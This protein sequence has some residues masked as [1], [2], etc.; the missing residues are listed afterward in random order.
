[1]EVSLNATSRLLIAV[2]FSLSAPSLLT[3]CVKKGVHEGVLDQLAQRNAAY[4]DLAT[5][6]VNCETLAADRASTISSTVLELEQ[7]TGRLAECNS[8][9]AESR[10]L[11]EQSGE[12]T[13]LL[14]SRLAD[15]AAV[16]A[17]LRERDAIFRSII[18]RFQSL[19][20]NGLLEVVV[21]R[22]RLSLKLPQDILFEPGSAEVGEEGEVT[23]REVATVL[24]SLGDRQFQVE[25]H[26]DNVPITRR[27]DSNWELSTARALAV[28]HIFV[29]AG[30]PPINVSAGGFGEFQPR[31]TNDTD[32]GR[33]L[34][35]RIEIVMVPNLENIFGDAVV[36]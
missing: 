34:N 31:A 14:A 3:G 1:L 26:T 7:Q 6:L 35:R 17:E 36:E 9:L 32:E 15:L 18:E 8:S 20:D 22:G 11:L 33:A 4:D 27:F 16:E 19:I 30:V 13:Q 10:S 21:E 2:V 25:G 23:L 28:V 24:A 5:E 12:E 29:D